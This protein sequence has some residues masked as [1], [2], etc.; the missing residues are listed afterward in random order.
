M[1][2]AVIIGTYEFLGFSL[3]KSLLEKGYQVNG[4]HLDLEEEDFFL[5]EKRMEVGRNANFNELSLEDWKQQNFRESDSVLIIISVYD[6][7]VKNKI[8][9]LLKDKQFW[10][11]SYPRFIK[12]KILML[13]PIQ[14]L[15]KNNEEIREEH[16]LDVLHDLFEK[17]TDHPSLTSVYIPTLFGPCQP[18]QFIFQ[19]TFL[20]RLGNNVK[21]VLKNHE[22]IFDAIYIEDSVNKIFDIFEKKS[23][24]SCYLK[25]TVN[26]SWLKCA[27]SLAIETNEV[28]GTE[29]EDLFIDSKVPA[30]SVEA[31]GELLDGLKKQ[32]DHLERIL[33]FNNMWLE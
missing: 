33:S 26:D 24:K 4:I 29:K 28:R 32:K 5:E 14:L 17:F 3:C 12:S 20:H 19:Q 27:K 23:I 6:Y 21:P 15:V 16:E 31:S 2:K 10:N 7:F 1:D 22:W 11:T 25:N 8:R 30:E 9:A 18:Q 13:L